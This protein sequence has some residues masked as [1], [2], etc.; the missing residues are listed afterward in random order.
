ML[1]VLTRV[2]LNR[3]LARPDGYPKRP[4]NEDVFCS[5]EA[6]RTENERLREEAT[7]HNEAWRAQSISCKTLRAANERLVKANKWAGGEMQKLAAR[8]EKAE[9]KNRLLHEGLDQILKQHAPRHLEVIAHNLRAGL[10]WY[11]KKLEA[12]CG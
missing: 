1:D 4:A 10:T 7:N 11:G 12:D 8:A 6:L 5:H 9:A 3:W 2:Q